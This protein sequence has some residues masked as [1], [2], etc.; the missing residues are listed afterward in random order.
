[1]PQALQEAAK[2]IRKARGKENPAIYSPHTRV[3]GPEE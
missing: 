2:R 3:K 1:M